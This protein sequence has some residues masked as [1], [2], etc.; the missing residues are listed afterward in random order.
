MQHLQ[1]A[2]AAQVLGCQRQVRAELARQQFAAVAGIQA[3]AAT[4]IEQVVGTR[5]A[6]QEMAREAHTLQRYGQAPG[7]FQ[8]EDGQGQWLAA[9]ALQYLVHHRRMGAQGVIFILLKAQRI[10]LAQQWLG[11]FA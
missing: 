3:P 5:H 8:S 11:Q 9:A 4:G 2:G 10:Q 6:Q 1:R 7:Q